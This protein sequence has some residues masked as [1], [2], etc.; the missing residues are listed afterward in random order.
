MG[1]GSNQILN[2]A[3]FPLLSVTIHKNF[4]TS[5]R[6]AVTLRGCVQKQALALEMTA[7]QGK[8][9]ISPTGWQ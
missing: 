3:H 2:L 1:N 4:P 5:P 8:V 7:S 6:R 9:L